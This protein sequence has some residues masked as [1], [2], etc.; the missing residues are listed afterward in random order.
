MILLCLL[1]AAFSFGMFWADFN[2]T[3][4][5]L[6]E[7]IGTITYKRQAAQRRFTDRVLWIRLSKG[8]PIYQGDYVRTAEQSQATMHFKDGADI[9]LAENTLIRIRVENG[10]N[11][12]DLSV[13]NLSVAVSGSRAL[14]VLVSGENR[15]EIGAGAAV[16]AAA[17]AGVFTM[18]VLEGEVTANGETFA[19][20]ES[21]S[22]DALAARTVPL[23]PRP[24]AYFFAAAGTAAVRFAWSAVNYSG[25]TR[26]ELAPDRRFRRLEQSL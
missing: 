4:D 2:R 11:V 5:R 9:D 8:A 18:R 13:G 21:F 20:G 14:R 25:P 1:G 26:F 15:V 16:S 24:D 6:A 10:K 17:G 23:S 3:M 7:P 12:V 22:S 19:A